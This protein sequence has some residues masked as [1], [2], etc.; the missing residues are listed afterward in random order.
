MEPAVDLERVER[1]VHV[2]GTTRRNSPSLLHL[3]SD[4]KPY[5]QVEEQ[6]RATPNQ[7]HRWMDQQMGNAKPHVPITPPHHLAL[8][9]PP[10]QAATRLPLREKKDPPPF[11]LQKTNPRNPR[12]DLP[13]ACDSGAP[14]SPL[15]SRHNL[16]CNPT[17]K[18]AGD[19]GRPTTDL[20]SEL[21]SHPMAFRAAIAGGVERG[22]KGLRGPAGALRGEHLC[23][24]SRT[25][26][27]FSCGKLTGTAGDWKARWQR[28]G[29]TY[30]ACVRAYG[31]FF[32]FFFFFFVVFVLD[33]RVESSPVGGSQAVC[34][35][36]DPRSPSFLAVF[37]LPFS[38]LTLAL[39]LALA[40][41]PAHA[42]PISNTQR[43]AP[44]NHGIHTWYIFTRPA[45]RPAG[46]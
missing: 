40:L 22:L 5:T 46:G 4:L 9:C 6:D 36:F 43:S 21:R 25:R 31:I 37:S 20:L 19:S 13:L 27:G 23:K 41:A 11:S 34:I 12:V 24:R 8:T 35:R 2:Q 15:L 39:T 10:Q 33:D 3:D 1:T 42:H 28:R 16:A 32:F 29:V 38:A 26:W 44:P 45:G 7:L 17:P 30:R 18:A 14:T